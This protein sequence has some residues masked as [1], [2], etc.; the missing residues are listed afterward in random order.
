MLEVIWKSHEQQK[1]V[2]ENFS[3]FDSQKY[4][5]ELIWFYNKNLD[6]PNSIQRLKDF[7]IRQEQ[8]KLSL[9]ENLEKPVINETREYL[10]REAVINEAKTMLYEK[11][12]LDK[13]KENNSSFENFIKWVIDWWIIDNYDLAIQVWETNWKIIIDWL[14]QLASWDWLKKLANEIWEDIWTLFDGDAYE[15]WKVSA[16]IVLT[17]LTVW[18]WLAVNATRKWIKFWIKEIV[19]FRVNK[20][21]L[22]DSPEVKSVVSETNS[23]VDKVLPKQEVNLDELAKRSIDIERQVKWLEEL[24]IPESYSRDMLESGLLNDKFMWWDLLRRFQA[25]QE[26]WIDYDTM[27]ENA[28]DDI[29][30]LSKEEA[31]TIFSYTDQVIY[32]NLNNYMRWI[33]DKDLSP[34]NIKAINNLIIKLESWLSKMPDIEWTFIY[35]WD[36]WNWWLKDIWDDIELKAFTS[37][38]DNVWDTFLS[39]EKNILVIADWK[40]WRVK[41]VTQLAII[42]NFWD[43]FPQIPNTT[44]EWVILPN[45]TV[46]VINKTNESIEWIDIE[47]VEVKQIK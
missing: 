27:I 8:S 37:V 32:K 4:Q 18:A 46:R 35:R 3:T 34:D 21:R 24:W 25:L 41:D 33:L 14:K 22:V 23:I 28:I 20:E 19:K 44:N 5:N 40:K 42:P 11:L 31:L 1:G 12:W 30:W 16:E 36:S 15:K 29:T 6:N 9:K 13:N 7:V 10:D 43:R 38:A 45:S 39:S 2:N 26:K 47:K 17:L